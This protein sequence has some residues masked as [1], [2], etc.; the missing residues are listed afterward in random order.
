MGSI[1]RVHV[2]YRDL[3]E[4]I[5]SVP[6]GIQVF[7]TV[8]EGEN[9]FE[10]VL[11]RGGMILIGNESRGLSGEL[12]NLAGR[13]FFIPHFGDKT[14]HAESLNASVAAGIVCCEFRRR[15]VQ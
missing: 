11:P 9:I 10:S 15:W 14:E 5:E 12:L 8:L 3:A 2:H 4:F 1:F 7:A 6:S 13:K